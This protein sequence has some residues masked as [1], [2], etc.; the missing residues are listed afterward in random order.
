MRSVM[1]SLLL[2]F[3]TAAQT[4]GRRGV[5]LNRKFTLKVGQEALIRPGGLRVRFSAVLEDSRCPEGVNCIWAGNARIAAGLSG[6]G[7]KPASV[8]L[9]SDVEPRQQTYM[10][11]E[12]KLLD[13]SPRPK[14]GETVDKKSYVA[15]LIVKR[16]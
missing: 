12:V 1:L 3:T 9:N 10:S 11:Y 6:A 14:E 16:K 7:G 2:L 5:L 8:E 4:G 13:L 15:T